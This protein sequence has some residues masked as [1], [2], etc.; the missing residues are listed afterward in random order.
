MGRLITKFV[1]GQGWFQAKQAGHGLND[2]HM[3]VK[4]FEEIVEMSR[5]VWGWKVISGKVTNPIWWNSCIRHIMKWGFS[6][7]MC[8]VE[9]MKPLA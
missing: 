1:G 8:V 9:N 7:K 4:R 2:S 5:N 3:I 6:C